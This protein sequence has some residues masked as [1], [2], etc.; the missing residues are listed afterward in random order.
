METNDSGDDA[1]ENIHSQ[2]WISVS[3]HKTAK[4][5]KKIVDVVF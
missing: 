4:G 2:I 3:R 1:V 5:R